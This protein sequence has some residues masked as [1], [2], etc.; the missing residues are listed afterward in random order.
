MASTRLSRAE[1]QVHTRARLL[2]SAEKVFSRLG[3]GGASVDLIAE[4]AG[5]S[6]GAVYSN[7]P[8]KEAMFLE[9]LRLYM[10]RDMAQLEKIVTQAPDR[11]FDTMSAWLKTMHID[12]DCPLLVTELQL[13]ARRSP[14]FAEQYYALQERQTATLAGILGRY[15][16]ASGCAMPLDLIDMAGALT[17]LA[18]GLSLQRPLQNAGEDSYAGRIIDQLIG[19]LTIRH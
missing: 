13:H 19:A 7:F 9:L 3:Y 18:H 2:A 11:L 8:T 10:E 5:F 1:Q 17:A 6:K 14:L 15:F 12:S 16:K 4:E